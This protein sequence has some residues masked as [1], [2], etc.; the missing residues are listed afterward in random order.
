MNRL[1][2]PHELVPISLTRFDRAALVVQTATIGISKVLNFGKVVECQNEQGKTELEYQ[3]SRKYIKLK[4]PQHTRNKTT[5]KGCGGLSTLIRPNN[6]VV[7][8]SPTAVKSTPS[9]YG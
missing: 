8:L 9:E 7:Y 3:T 5:G 6:L 1:I 4:I 2:P